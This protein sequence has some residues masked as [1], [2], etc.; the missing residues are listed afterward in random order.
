[1]AAIA[2]TAVEAQFKE[3]DDP[4]VKTVADMMQVYKTMLESVG[5]EVTQIFFKAASLRSFSGAAMHSPAP[6]KRQP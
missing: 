2:L 6:L 3:S 1:M 4:N 5:N